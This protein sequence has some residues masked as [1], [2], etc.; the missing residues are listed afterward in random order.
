MAAEPI[1]DYVITSHAAFEMMRRGI[2]N[3]TV[4]RVMIAPEQRLP[5][6]PGRLVL[7][8]RVE[9]ETQGKVALVRVFVDIERTPA[10][11]VTV[12]LTSKVAKYWD[13]SHED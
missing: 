13:A 12:Y 11:V 1:T 10:E 7:Q 6:R 3:E 8:S 5:V 2:S 9:R 4:H